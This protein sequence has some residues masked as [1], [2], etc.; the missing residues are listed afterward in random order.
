MEKLLTTNQL[1]EY[2]GVAVSTVLQYRATGAEPR[3]MKLGHLVRYRL[4]DVQEWLDSK[5]VGIG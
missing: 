2:L 4:A 1:A 5:K 3:Y